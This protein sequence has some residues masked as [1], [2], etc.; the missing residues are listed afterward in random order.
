MKDKTLVIHDLHILNDDCLKISYDK[1]LDDASSG[2]TTNVLIAAFTTCHARLRL[3]HHLDHVGENA[4]Y[5]SNDS[6]VYKWQPGQPDILLGNFLGEM[7]DELDNGKGNHDVIVKFLS[8]GP[9]NNAYKTRLGETEVKIR[10]FTLNMRGKTSCS[11][12][13]EPFSLNRG[14]SRYSTCISSSE[15]RTPNLDQRPTRQ[16]MGRRL[17]KKRPLR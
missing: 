11:A 2:Q 5:F 17:R 13:F 10:E 9:K 1:F 16:T 4:L 8:C 7:N 15:T 14:L 6:V 12:N 3:Y